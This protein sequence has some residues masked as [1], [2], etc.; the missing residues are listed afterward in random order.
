MFRAA[1]RTLNPKEE[2]LDE[3]RL[4]NVRL[5]KVREIKVRLG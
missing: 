3:V 5:A 1:V 2:K 4:V